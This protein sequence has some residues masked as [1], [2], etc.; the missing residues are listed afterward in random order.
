MELEVPGWGQQKRHRARGTGV[1][2]RPPPTPI[3]LDPA[4]APLVFSHTIYTYVSLYFKH[5][6]HRHE[7]KTFPEMGAEGDGAEDARYECRK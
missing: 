1:G 7:R 4:P 2:I 3:Y 5:L 6:K